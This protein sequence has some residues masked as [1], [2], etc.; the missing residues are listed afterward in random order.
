MKRK[1]KYGFLGCL[2]TVFVLFV[3]CAGLLLIGQQKSKENAGW[4]EEW[5]DGDGT[6]LRNLRYGERTNNTYDLTIP[7]GEVK[8][9]LLLFVHG[10]SWMG[11]D[12]SDMEYACR[13]YAKQGYV[14]ATMNYSFINSKE[15]YG[16]L[17]IIDGEV[18]QCLEA[19]K[20]ELAKHGMQVNNLAI[21]GHSA[22]G[23]IAATYAMKHTEDSPI[24]IRFAIV[25]AGPVDLAKMFY[26]S[27]QQLA[28][29][30]TALQ[31]GK[32][33]VKEKQDVDGAVMN[34]SN[35]QMQPGMY[36]KQTV[37]S[38]L[39]ISSA[40]SLVGPNSAAV[41]M[42]YGAKDWLVKPEQYQSLEAACK[43]YSRPYTL[44]VY[45]NSGHQLDGDPDKVQELQAE[46]RK[47]L[48]KYFVK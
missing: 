15:E 14:T 19:I 11:G 40:A 44:I 47:Y 10:G 8:N 35:V 23:Q 39:N 30:R 43:R 29:I 18:V 45:P 3:G 17:P 7:K 27:E 25:M 46:V 34:A 37:D 6:V 48:E 42:A 22:G 9:G 13:R 31:D 21:G 26:V 36:D 33:D 12:K 20:Q 4:T 41:I 1:T 24:P 2:L 32:T 38:L 28:T 5:N 16:S